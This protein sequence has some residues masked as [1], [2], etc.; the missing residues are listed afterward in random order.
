MPNKTGASKEDPY[1]IHVSPV[2]DWSLTGIFALEVVGVIRSLWNQADYLTYFC[3]L[4]VVSAIG[5]NT[6]HGSD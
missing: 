3:I 5:L 6:T 4:T 1:A 2:V